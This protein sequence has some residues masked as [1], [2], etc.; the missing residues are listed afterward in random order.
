MQVYGDV[1]EAS[2]KHT[3]ETIKDEL[4]NL[5]GITLAEVAGARNSEIHIE[6]SEN[7]LRKYDLTLA[8]VAAA[9]R[10][11]QSSICRPAVLKPPREKVLI[12]AKGR[13]YYAKN[14]QD[15]PVITR[16]DGNK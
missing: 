3:A 9:A 6:I 1:S 4:T 11:K 16:S 5:P 2:L 13:R 7:T 14:Y 15:I 12:R 10:K 8:M